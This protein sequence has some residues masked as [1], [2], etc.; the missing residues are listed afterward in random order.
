MSALYIC[1]Q[2][3]LDPLT[4][5]QVVAYLEGIASDVTPIV[6]LTFEPSKLTS[7][8]VRTWE[9]RLS[10]KGIVWRR[11]PYH[12]R[13]TL[14]ATLWD[15][16]AGTLAGYRIIREFDVKLVHARSHVPALMGRLLKR[17][18]GVKFLFDFRGLLAEEYVDAGIWKRNGTLFRL[19]KRAERQLISAADAYVVLTE[20][21]RDVLVEW[22][23]KEIGEKPMA[24]IPCCA[25]LTPP[26]EI[27]HDKKALTDRSTSLTLVY[28]GKL[29]GWYLTDE[30][31]EFFAYVASVNP[32]VRWSVWTQGDSQRL[33]AELS[34]RGLADRVTIGRTTPHEL[35][36]YLSSARA[37]LAFI[38]P[39]LSKKA[40]SPTKVAEYL[41]AGLPVISTG[42]IGD[43]DAVLR[44]DFSEDGQPVG[45]ILR[46]H[47]LTA[48]AQT[49]EE[50]CEL[51]NDPDTPSRCRDVAQHLF[52]L[53]TVGWSRYRN[54]YAAILN[55][56]AVILSQSDDRADTSKEKTPSRISK[57]KG[58]LGL[59]SSLRK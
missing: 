42:G 20:Q 49:W 7:A 9:E 26:S 18:T 55:R 38:R 12:K 35:R 54:L 53:K 24:V 58:D 23:T 22:Y 56:P 36:K 52:D 16:M 48:Y 45:V 13:P 30:M 47:S 6:L 59:V 4:Q 40:S 10:E 11:L 43:L 46:D 39:C 25:D 15:V 1:Y 29:D 2:S 33:Q 51:L 50:L 37:G 19:T 44:G 21:A 27:N 5:T 3:L 8:E 17:L 14:P 28:A 31:I 34:R 41:A 32:Q 57:Q